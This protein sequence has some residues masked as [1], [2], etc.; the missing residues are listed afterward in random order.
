MCQC[1]RHVHA[2]AHTRTHI[3]SLYLG[4][5]RG[6]AGKRLILTHAKRNS[7]PMK[8]Q[9]FHPRRGRDV[10]SFTFEWERPGASA[11]S[12]ECPHPPPTTN[13]TRS[14]PLIPHSAGRKW[15]CVHTGRTRNSDESPRPSKHWKTTT[16]ARRPFTSHP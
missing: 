8:L 16:P 3:S 15:A 11:L 14:V 1:P 6:A 4:F 10:A 7:L 12:S 13:G 2:R 5:K 9:C